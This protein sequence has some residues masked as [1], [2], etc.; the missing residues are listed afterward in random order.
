M[1]SYLVCM[2]I[3][4]S[5][6]NSSLSNSL[7]RKFFSKYTFIRTFIIYDADAKI[8][9]FAAPANRLSRS[10]SEPALQLGLSSV[11]FHHLL[12]EENIL[13]EASQDL[14]HLLIQS[15]SA[16][17]FQFFGDTVETLCDGSCNA[18]QRITVATQGNCGTNDIFKGFT[19]QESQVISAYATQKCKCNA[20]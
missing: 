7:L 4:I 9:L 2:R 19:F 1:S 16:F 17:S 20:V 12:L 8:N 11:H 15:L 6:V 5:A 10:I 18:G 13:I 14:S 3:D